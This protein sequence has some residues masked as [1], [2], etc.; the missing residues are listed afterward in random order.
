M[1]SWHSSLIKQPPAP[2]PPPPPPVLTPEEEH[3]LFLSSIFSESTSGNPLPWVEAI[4][5]KKLP[6]EFADPNGFTALHISVWLNRADCVQN[7]LDNTSCAIDL[8]SSNGKTPLMLAAATGNL[9]LLKLFLDRGADIE[10][11]DN[12]GFT[13]ILCAAHSG[14]INCVY[15]LKARGANILAKDA[16]GSGAMHLAAAK[17]RAT[18]LRVLRKLDMDIDGISD[19]GDTPLH[20]AAASN[21]LETIEYLLFEGAQRDVRDKVKGLTPALLADMFEIEGPSQVIYHYSRYKYP[22]FIYFLMSYWA[23]IGIVYY[24]Y[25]MP[26]SLRH[27]FISLVFNLAGPSVLPLFL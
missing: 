11:K 14:Q 21:S 24:F 4:L 18:M 19:I 12:S 25:V 17:N 13:P 27:L 7:I 5:S 26:N 8:R 9:K 6:C 1:A 3:T 23:L 15:A 22:W 16:S 20:R 2:P 10:G